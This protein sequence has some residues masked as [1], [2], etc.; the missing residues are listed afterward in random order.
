M[1]AGF[2]PILNSQ[3]LPTFIHTRNATKLLFFKHTLQ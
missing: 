2:N 1:F 3:H